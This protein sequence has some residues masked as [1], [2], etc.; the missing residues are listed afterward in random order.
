MTDYEKFKELLALFVTH[1]ESKQS[2]GKDVSPLGSGNNQIVNN[3]SATSYGTISVTVQYHPTGGYIS[4]RCNLEWMDGNDDRTG[5]N[6]NCGEKGC[7]WDKNKGVIKKLYIQHCTRGGKFNQT[8]SPPIYQSDVSDLDLTSPDPPNDSLK[9]LFDE[10]VKAFDLDEFIKRN[11]MAQ[12]EEKI[13]LLKSNKNLI[14]IG[15]PGTGKTFTA[16]DIA[17]Q[18]ILGSINSDKKQQ[19][20]DLN[21]SE[22]YKLVQFHPA[23]TYEDFV[24]G[25]VAETN[26]NSV[27]YA[28]KNKTLAAFAEKAAAETGNQQQGDDVEKEIDEKLSYVLVIDEINRANLPAVLG[29]LIYALEYR[30]R[31]IETMYENEKSEKTPKDKNLTIP[32]N[33]F[34]IGTMNT[35][36]RSAG[37]VD[38]AIRRRFVFVPVLPKILDDATDLNGKAKFET[39]LFEAV[40][41]LFVDNYTETDIDKL[42][43]SQH[44]SSEFKPE[45]VWIGHSYFI[46]DSQKTRNKRLRYEIKPLL[47]EYLK[48][49]ILKAS[50]KPDIDKLA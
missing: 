42:V 16:Q 48:D 9:K 8:L 34:I 3:L 38:Y 17:A 4:T 35:A 41:K 37:Q 14:L 7:G 45:D 2:G 22:R 10:Y 49:G 6:I 31:A 40:S 24:R 29:E 27:A 18:M 23:Y 5:L 50:A 25:I 46:T 36:D 30:D 11:Y 33:L 15:A 47:R 39:D 32:S 28:V 43:P 12:I 21:K 13:D 20:E 44:L 1:L 26:G 19:T